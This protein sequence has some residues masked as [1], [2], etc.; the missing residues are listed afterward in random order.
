MEPLIVDIP[1]TTTRSFVVTLPVDG[2]TLDL[3]D[4]RFPAPGTVTVDVSPVRE[5]FLLT[6]ELE[7]SVE[8]ECSRCLEPVLWSVREQFRIVLARDA[9]GDEGEDEWVLFPRGEHEYDLSPLVREL[10]VVALPA[11]PLCSDG[12]AGICPICGTDRNRAPCRCADGEGDPRWAALRSLGF[13]QPC[14]GEVYDGTS[15]EEDIEEPT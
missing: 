15:E 5:G 8:L 11:K 7:M 10:V 1:A 6:G 14:E 12:C 9:M 3:E 2:A 4:L 13:D